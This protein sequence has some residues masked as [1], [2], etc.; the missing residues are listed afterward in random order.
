MRSSTAA[1]VAARQAVCGAAARTHAPH[2]KESSMSPGRLARAPRFFVGAGGAGQP[3]AYQETATATHSYFPRQGLSM[4]KP[5]KTP[6]RRVRPSRG[7]GVSGRRGPQ[8]SESCSA[9]QRWAWQTTEAS[10][11]AQ[12][13]A[14]EL[15]HA[16]RRRLSQCA[17]T[18]SERGPHQGF[19]NLSQPSTGP[20]AERAAWKSSRFSSTIS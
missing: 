7:A 9:V 10:Q 4:R 1:R 3:P 11:L 15:R 18:S 5:R 14:P 16:H 13:G 2:T 17:K 6:V 12:A 20:P 19:C 8:G